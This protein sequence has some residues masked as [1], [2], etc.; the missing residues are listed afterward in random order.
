MDLHAG[1]WEFGHMTVESTDG[2]S[3]ELWSNLWLYSSELKDDD[4]T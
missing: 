4:N 2:R 1:G 3:P